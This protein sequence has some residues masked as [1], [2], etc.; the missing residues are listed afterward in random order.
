[1]RK[2]LLILL[3]LVFALTGCGKNGSNQVQENKEPNKVV[4][5]ED[6]TETTPEEQNTEDAKQTV[7]EVFEYLKNLNFTDAQ[8]HISVDAIKNYIGAELTYMDAEEFMNE[9]FDTLNC[10]IVSAESTDDSNVSVSVKITARDM[11]E[12][13]L[14]HN[15]AADSYMKDNID[16]LYA[17]P[18]DQRAEMIQTKSNELFKQFVQNEE[19]E[20]ITS[21]VTLHLSNTDGVWVIATD[22]ELFNA[23]LGDLSGGMNALGFTVTQ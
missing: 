13:L 20:S 22:N 10:E 19:Y 12:L 17:Y 15:D 8:N 18:Q 2:R 1:M 14:M 11:K 4:E 16:M 3:V 5:N 9:W 21:S 23:L 7:E 6:G